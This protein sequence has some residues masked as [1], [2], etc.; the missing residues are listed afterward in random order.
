MLNFR[1]SMNILIKV[2]QFQGING[3]T[4]LAD[5]GRVKMVLYDSVKSFFMKGRGVLFG[6]PLILGGAGLFMYY[7][8][9]GGIAV[10]VGIILLGASDYFIETEEGLDG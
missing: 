5:G 6:F 3:Y 1:A 4:W 7:K 2:T 9:P 8:I 10:L